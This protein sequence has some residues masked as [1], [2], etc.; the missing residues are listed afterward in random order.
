MDKIFS[1]QEVNAGQWTR[2]TV[3]DADLVRQDGTERWLR[4]PFLPGKRQALLLSGEKGRGFVR[5][6]VVTLLLRA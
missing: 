1:F 4:S 3:E 6:K 2:I 5:V